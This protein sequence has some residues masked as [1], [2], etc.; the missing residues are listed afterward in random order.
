MIVTNTVAY[1]D[2]DTI[3]AVNCFVIADPLVEVNDSGKH[4]SF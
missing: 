3:A 2:T 1:Y 4:S